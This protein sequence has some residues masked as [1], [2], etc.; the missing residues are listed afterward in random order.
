MTEINNMEGNL[1]KIS[2]EE[3]SKRLTKEN[4]NDLQEVTINDFQD[5]MQETSKNKW[6]KDEIK[7][8][9]EMNSMSK[10]NGISLWETMKKTV[11]VSLKDM[12]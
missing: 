3:L 5:E 10:N 9:K 2:I 12:V 4:I 7:V 11:G 8:W 1:K 6:A